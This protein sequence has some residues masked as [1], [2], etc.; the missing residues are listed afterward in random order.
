MLLS[1][2]DADILVIQECEDPETTKDNLYHE[3]A[4]K[5]FWTGERK[6]KGL[7]IFAKEG[8]AIRLLDWDCSAN[9]GTLESA[10]LKYF[11]S[12][13][14]NEEFTMLGTWCHGAD[15]PAFQYIGQFWQYL[16]KHKSKLTKTIIAGDFNSN[17]IW[18]RKRRWWNHSDVVRELKEL[19]IESAYHYMYKEEPGRESRPTFFLQKNKS[20]PYH[21]D[22]VF[23]SHEY[24]KLFRTFQ[25]G[26]IEDWI[27][28]SDH[29]PV[30]CEF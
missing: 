19:K 23:A 15:S 1:Q 25:V 13:K 20:K 7:G 8:I 26:K 24:L 22:Y 11:V 4:R 2:F 18:D 6:H 29:M 27:A 9:Y 30:V 10:T 28:V 5:F 14:I 16:Q 21:I 12:C 17:V 3:W